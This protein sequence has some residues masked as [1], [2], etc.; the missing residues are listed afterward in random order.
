[1]FQESGPAH[2]AYEESTPQKITRWRY[3]TVKCHRHTI[4]FPNFLCYKY[5]GHLVMLSSINTC[6]KGLGL[7]LKK[8]VDKSSVARSAIVGKAQKNKR[9]ALC[10]RWIFL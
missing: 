2:K 4:V 9:F 3:V 1:M 6:V 7:D 5:T 8:M 10:S